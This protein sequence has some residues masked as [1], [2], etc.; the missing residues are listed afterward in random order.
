MR[1]SESAQ[2][3]TLH[4]RLERIETAGGTGYF[5]CSPPAE[6]SLNFLWDYLKSHPLD[7]F[8]HRHLLR[9]G[10]RFP[11]ARIE[12]LIASESDPAIQALLYEF[13]LLNPRLAELK[14]R[15][16]QD[17]AQ[18]LS[19]Q[20]PLIYIRSHRLPDQALHGQWIRIFAQNIL[21]HQPLPPPDAVDL[22][23]PVSGSAL[24]ADDWVNISQIPAET[25][26][27]LALPSIAE[28][29][30]LALERLSAISAVAGEE[31]RHVASL[32]P[33]ALL[34]NWRADIWVESGRHRYRLSGEQ[35][36]YGRGLDWESAR[37]SYA[38][39]MVERVCAYANIG[40][41]GIL[42]GERRA[43][44]CHA[45]Y[46]QLRD[47]GILA[48]DPNRL[49]LEVPYENAPLYW[50]EGEKAG[51]NRP[52]LIWVPA[53][54][55]FLFANLDEIHLFSGLGS[56]GLGAGITPEGARLSALLEVLE[57]DADAT[58]PHD[59]GRCFTIET[60]D[61]ALSPL[62]SDYEKKGISVQFEAITSQMGVPCY[63]A[64]VVG[65]QAQIV[66]G[67]AADLS[68]KKAVISA[69]TETPYPYPYGPPSRPRPQN[70]PVHNLSELPD[71]STGNPKAD[72]A[73]LESLLRAN[74]FDVIYLDLSRA[75]LRFPVVRAI[76]PGME[77][78]GD[79]DACSRV[80]PRLFANYLALFGKP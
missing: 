59:P 54:C 40:P 12:T 24:P 46:A 6:L 51:E 30:A 19:E 31:M 72:L 14:D 16:P 58:T 34:R 64:F 23:W 5:A 33:C 2:T 29:A 26:A 61:P 66:K 68:G 56:T 67:C 37:V 57:R 35:T 60:E 20:T 75:D 1:P 10:M 42:G 21:A 44:L 69:F 73:R 15:F 28:T 49:C 9:I 65:P 3:K 50:M 74:G 18:K 8:A 77:L 41:E 78:L 17:A 80:H 52:A 25:A 62:L 47:Q 53:Q 39:E 7:A 13:C 43:P 76:V 22:P 32:A 11:K 45:S 27:P 38:M 55:A 63:R 70:L 36:V 71:Y 79:F 48:L 4:Y